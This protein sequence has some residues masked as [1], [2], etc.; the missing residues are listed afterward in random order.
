MRIIGR[1][2]HPEFS[3]SVFEMNE[4]FVVKFEAGPMEQT[5][6]FL[7]E[8]LGSMESIEALFDEEFINNIRRRFEGMYLDMK[9]VRS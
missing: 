7:K 5:Y 9:R 6:K 4:K 3:I 8:G 1:I 2:P